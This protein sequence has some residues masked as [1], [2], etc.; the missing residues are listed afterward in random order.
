MPRYEGRILP[1]EWQIVRRWSEE[2]NAERYYL[3]RIGTDGAWRDVSGPYKQR[4]PAYDYYTR[5]RM[6]Y[7]SDQRKALT[8]TGAPCPHEWID[9]RGGLWRCAICAE[10]RWQRDMPTA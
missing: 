4:G 1:A 7:L 2:A 6:E 3:Q 9:H 10:E 8:A 5:R